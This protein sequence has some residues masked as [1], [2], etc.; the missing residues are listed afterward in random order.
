LT[1]LGF[2]FFGGVFYLVGSGF[3]WDKSI[4]DK[5]WNWGLTTIYQTTKEVWSMQGLVPQPQDLF[6]AL[7]KKKFSGDILKK[8]S[9]SVYIGHREVA[10]LVRK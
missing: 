1:I 6:E 7:K 2:F 9:I 3:F 8:S 5:N 10:A 4:S